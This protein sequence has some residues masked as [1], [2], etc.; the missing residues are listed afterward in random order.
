MIDP[1]SLPKQISWYLFNRHRKYGD[2]EWIIFHVLIPSTATY[3]AIFIL[4]RWLLIFEFDAMDDFYHSFYYY[5]DGG[6]TMLWILMIAGV[7][8]FFWRK[9]PKFADVWLIRKEISITLVLLIILILD[10]II[11]V[12]L[13]SS[14]LPVFLVGIMIYSGIICM[15]LYLMLIYPQTA[16]IRKARAMRKRIAKAEELKISWQELV[17]SKQGYESFMNFLEKELSTEN[18]LFLTE[19]VQLKS[20]MLENP[21]LKDIIENKLRLS[22]SINLPSSL[23]VETK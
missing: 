2:E 21:E 23:P 15:D 10:L 14:G 17:S 20:M 19:Y 22:Y 18:L 3:S 9:Y 4:I 8:A 1:K 7:A 13:Q 12:L 16:E 6:S 11:I 5:C